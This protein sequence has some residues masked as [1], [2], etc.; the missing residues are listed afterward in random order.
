MPITE[1]FAR[2]FASGF[3]RWLSGSTN[4]GIP[5]YFTIVS[6]GESN[7]GGE[8][9]NASATAWELL[10]RPELQILN[11]STS[12]YAPLDIG[13]NNNLGHFGLDSTKHAWENGLANRCRTGFFG[14]SRM[15][16]VQTGQG[17]SRLN[18][19]G[20]VGAYWLAFVART[21]AALASSEDDGKIAVWVTF[22]INDILAGTTDAAFEVGFTELL[23]RIK[24]QLP[25]CRIYV[26]KLM[27]NSDQKIAYNL[28]IDAVAA[29]DVDVVAIDITGLTTQDTHHW[30]YASQ[31]N[32]ANRICRAMS[33]DFSGLGQITWS[34]FVG[35]NGEF[36]TTATANVA[37]STTPI[38]SSEPFA[39]VAG[40]PSVNG[41]VVTLSS[42]SVARPWGTN[43]NRVAAW[44]LFITT[45]I[46]YGAVGA[47]TAVVHATG[48]P[49]TAIVRAQKSG[50]DIV[51]QT[52]IDGGG[53]WV[54]ATT[55]TGVLSGVP[56]VWVKVQS[57]SIAVA[58]MDVTLGY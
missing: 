25:G 20:A 35:S 54:T 26:S 31:K 42:D 1:N 10:P 33:S 11:L 51:L 58:S 19:W 53:T 23:G 57:S 24:A 34:N 29:A 55:L 6:F 47:A 50:N 15:A 43:I 38:D 49:A 39:V 18:Q 22:G 8:V 37:V 48:L 2:C 45:G 9:A 28:K 4:P 17:G 16:L 30:D 21:N 14:S 3:A 32:L 56:N 27:T 46:L 7:S 12:L 5:N 41:I 13:T 40:V 44:Y 36:S 52:S